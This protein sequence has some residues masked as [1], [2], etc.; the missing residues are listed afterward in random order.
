MFDVA[1]NRQKQ[2]NEKEQGPEKKVETQ[3]TSRIPETKGRPK[4]TRNERV[5]IGQNGRWE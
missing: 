2:Y 1:A 3:E 4:E 5:V